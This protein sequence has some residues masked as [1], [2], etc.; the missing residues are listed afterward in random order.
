MLCTR[1]VCDTPM[2]RSGKLLERGIPGRIRT[3]GL[4]VIDRLLCC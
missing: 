2:L 1:V 3:S 4:P